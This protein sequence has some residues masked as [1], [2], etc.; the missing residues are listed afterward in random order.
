MNTTNSRPR[1]I[2]ASEVDMAV[3]EALQRVA[4]A[5]VLADDECAK[6]SGGLMQGPTGFVEPP[7]GDSI[8]G[9]GDPTGDTD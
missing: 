4:Q 5:R 7:V 8:G 6:V 3:E 9:L 2:L 1:T